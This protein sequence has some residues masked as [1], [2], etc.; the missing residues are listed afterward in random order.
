MN[1][2]PSGYIP[3]YKDEERR[4]PKSSEDIKNFDDRVLDF[5]LLRQIPGQSLTFK[6]SPLRYRMGTKATIQ[7]KPEFRGD[8]FYFEVKVLELPASKT[9][10]F[11]GVGL[12]QPGY[13]EGLVGWYSKSVGYNGHCFDDGTFTVSN[14]KEEIA[15]TT[16]DKSDTLFVH[17]KMSVSYDA[18]QLLKQNEVV[19][20]YW[21]RR[22]GML[23]FTRNGIMFD[24]KYKKKEGSFVPTITADPGISFNVNLGDEPFVLNYV[25]S[26]KQD[27]F[28]LAMK[29]QC[30]NS[31]KFFDCILTFGV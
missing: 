21:N 13:G 30:T 5:Y 23:K 25:P 3:F 24:K 29:S 19:G 10:D 4:R 28:R 12:A 1:L 9:W 27:L 15:D 26:I 16:Y 18:D 8:V 6:T 22:T 14:D 31:N 11:F 17:E 20:L 2:H 7:F